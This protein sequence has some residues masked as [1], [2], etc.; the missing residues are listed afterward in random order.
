MKPPHPSLERYPVII[1]FPLHWGDQD[2]L[3]HVN[4]IIYFRWAESVRIEYLARTGIW[5]GSA[6]AAT[7][8]IVAAIS[9]D[10]RVPLTYPDT[11]YAGASVTALGNSSF[12]MAHCIVSA[13]RG[14]VAAELDSTLVWL[15]YRTGKPLH[16]PSEVRKAIAE[17]EGKT[18]PRLAKNRG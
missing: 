5:D 9:C 3:S 10:F 15:D 11:V 7:G 8:P 13:N 18:P 1:S 12:Q 4:N 6:T 16:L 2:A 17:L 14:A